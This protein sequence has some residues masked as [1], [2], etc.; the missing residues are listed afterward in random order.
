MVDLTI[1]VNH[2]TLALSRKTHRSESGCDNLIGM[3]PV[4]QLHTIPP[5]MISSSLMAKTFKPTEL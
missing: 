2:D 5:D 1:I 3:R 4:A